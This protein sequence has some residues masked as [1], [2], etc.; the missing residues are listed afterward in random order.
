MNNYPPGVDT[1][2]TE[3]PWMSACKCCH[4]PC[5]EYLGMCEVC[6][7]E[8]KDSIGEDMARDYMN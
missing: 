3:A 1:L 6:I 7:Q 2:T 8:E 4:E 5:D